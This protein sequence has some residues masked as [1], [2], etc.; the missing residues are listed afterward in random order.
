[1][2][3]GK[4]YIGEELKYAVRITA[5][6]FSMDGDDFEIVVSCG[7]R[8]RTYAKEDLLLDLQGNYYLAIDTSEF[9]KGDLYATVYAYVPDDDFPDGKRTEIY[10]TKLTTLNGLS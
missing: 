5:S 7:S 2:A 1:M 3:Q 8:K 10:K 6:G 9:K 4:D